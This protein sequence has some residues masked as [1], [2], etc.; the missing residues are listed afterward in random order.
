MKNFRTGLHLLADLGT[1][2]FEN[3]EKVIRSGHFSCLCYR[4]STRPSAFQ[5]EETRKVLELCKSAGMHCLVEDDVTL[6]I[7][8]GAQGI[9]LHSSGHDLTTVRNTLGTDTIIGVT[10]SN[11]REA[12]LALSRGADYLYWFDQPVACPIPSPA[13]LIPENFAN[14]KDSRAV[15]IVAPCLYERQSASDLLQQGADALLFSLEA[16][17]DSLNL[18]DLEEL[19]LLFNRSTPYPR[20]SVL[21]IAGSDSGGGA[22]IQGD[23]KTI[24]LLGGYASCVV[25]CLTAQNTLGVQATYQPPPGFFSEQLHAVLRDIPIDVIKTG[26]L[27]SAELIE[28]LVD[29]LDNYRPRILVVD[30]VMTAK[31]GWDLLEE[32]ARATL[33]SRLLP[34]SYLVTPNIP[35]AEQLTGLTITDEQGMIAAASALRKLGARNVLIKGGHLGGNTSTDIL[36]EDTAIHRFTAQRIH[37][38]NTHGTGCTYA[39]AIAALLAQGEALPRAVSQA[40]RFVTAA[41]HHARPLGAGSGPLNHFLAAKMFF[42]SR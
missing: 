14:V 20:G 9:H 24:T 13:D 12:E 8:V 2:T 15:T 1:T 10:V 23:L 22:G 40:K 5:D 38:G 7:R 26:M 41:I 17:P 18:L 21:T 16:L 19:T 35:E 11:R 39:S 33:T 32:K 31:G 29:T 36:V 28:T 27:H 4:N 6:A 37:H 25:S 3:L 34:R 30:P 42:E